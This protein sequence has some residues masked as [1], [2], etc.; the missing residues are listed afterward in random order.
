ML[1]CIHTEK[2]KLKHLVNS[3]SLFDLMFTIYDYNLKQNS[4]FNILLNKFRH[5]RN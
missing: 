2:A 5:L 3:S 1:R 4:A